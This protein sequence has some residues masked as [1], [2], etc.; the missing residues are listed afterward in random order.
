MIKNAHS[1]Q[2]R[3]KNYWDPPNSYRMLL[4]NLNSQRV[5]FRILKIN[6]VYLLRSDFST[7]NYFGIIPLFLNIDIYSSLFKKSIKQFI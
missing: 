2:D 4:I 3:Y 6:R 1:A 7:I 5:L